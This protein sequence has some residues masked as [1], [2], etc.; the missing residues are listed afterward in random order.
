[1]LGQYKRQRDKVR[2]YKAVFVPNG[3]LDHN[4]EIVLS[5]LRKFCGIDITDNGNDS[6]LLQR[7]AG[8]REAYNWI[9]QNIQYKNMFEL[10][11]T[12]LELEE[13]YEDE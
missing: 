1:M 9:I 13:L 7:F 6:V 3:E 4:S 2:A 12:I 8:R 11:K 10:D 5:D